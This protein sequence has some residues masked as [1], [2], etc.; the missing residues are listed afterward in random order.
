[1]GWG[2]NGEKLSILTVLRK[3]EKG[4][5]HLKRGW[6]AP[7]R[8]ESADPAHVQYLAW[9]FADLAIHGSLC[10]DTRGSLRNGL[11]SPRLISFV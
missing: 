3:V 9:A 10:F 7:P 5:L 2:K 4:L 1:M 11:F 8:K 6:L